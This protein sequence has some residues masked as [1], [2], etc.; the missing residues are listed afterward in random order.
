[1]THLCFTHTSMPGTILPGCPSATIYCM[2]TKYNGMLVGT[3]T[4]IQLTSASDVKGQHHKI[5]GV[6]FGAAPIDVPIVFY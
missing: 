2:A 4:A 6:T 3:S 1:M 5:G